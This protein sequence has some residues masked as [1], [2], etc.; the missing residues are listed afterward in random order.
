MKIM[1]FLRILIVY[2][3]TVQKRSLNYLSRCF[4][5]QCVPFSVLG[6]LDR[7]GCE[8]ENH[9]RVLLGLPS[10]EHGTHCTRKFH[11]NEVISVNVF[12]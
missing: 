9:S 1:T 10:I 3:L 8:T 11:W 2:H 7:T 6:S 12:A 4:S 5:V